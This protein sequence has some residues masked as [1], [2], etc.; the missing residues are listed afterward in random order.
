MY[1]KYKSGDKV[2]I[3][4]KCPYHSEWD[5]DTILTLDR[6]YSD[7]GF[8]GYNTNEN[9]DWY[10]IIENNSGI[11]SQYFSLVESAEPAVTKKEE[12]G[13]GF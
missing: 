10:V 2:R 4:T 5:V 8:K 7:Q 9:N 11:Q 12:T 13:W 1:S 6:S 3:T